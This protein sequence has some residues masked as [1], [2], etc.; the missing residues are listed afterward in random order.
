MIEEEVE[1]E[2]FKRSKKKHRE[3]GETPGTTNM[4]KKTNKM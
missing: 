2:K 4:K 3:D 1:L